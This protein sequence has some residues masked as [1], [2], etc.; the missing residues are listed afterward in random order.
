MVQ[1]KD[2]LPQSIQKQSES[3]ISNNRQSETQQ[4]Q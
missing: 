4:T 3:I 2:I 1:E